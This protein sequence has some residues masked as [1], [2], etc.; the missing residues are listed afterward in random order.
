MAFGNEDFLI[1]L[2]AYLAHMFDTNIVD[3]NDAK[4]LSYQISGIS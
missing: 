2:L 4:L 3:S 1:H